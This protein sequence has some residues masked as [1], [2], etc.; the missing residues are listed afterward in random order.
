MRG[1]AGG[2]EALLAVIHPQ[3]ARVSACDPRAPAQDQLTERSLVQAGQTVDCHAAQVH[4]AA[5][6]ML[7]LLSMSCLC[8]RSCELGREGGQ[9]GGVSLGEHSCS[10]VDRLHNR[11]NS[12]AAV[13]SSAAQHVATRL[14][15]DGDFLDLLQL[16]MLDAAKVRH[17]L[18]CRCSTG[19]SL[20]DGE[21]DER[22][23]QLFLHPASMSQLQLQLPP[24]ALLLC[25]LLRCS[26]LRLQLRHLI[27]VPEALVE[28]D[29]LLLRVHEEEIH[30]LAV[31]RLPQ[32]RLCALEEAEGVSMMVGEGQQSLRQLLEIQQSD[33]P[34]DAPEGLDHDDAD[35]IFEEQLVVGG[36][37]L[38]LLGSHALDDSRHSAISHDGAAEHAH[39]VL[40][41][42]P[43]RRVRESRV[44]VEV[45]DADEGLLEG[46]VT[47]DGV[48]AAGDATLVAAGV[49]GEEACH[50]AIQQV[51]G[52]GRAGHELLHVL[53]Q[54]SEEL[55]EGRQ[56]GQAANGVQ[57]GA[58]GSD[59]LTCVFEL[60]LVLQ[61]LSKVGGDGLEPLLVLEGELPVALVHRQ[62][63]PH[64]IPSSVQQS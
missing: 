42:P 13:D 57:E 16:L 44:L 8:H 6:A 3:L 36:E 59:G 23:L 20:P 21:R 1:R 29:R 19:H 35:E 37:L 5:P 47:Y 18:T 48:G 25:C 27:R 62:H 45:G 12:L 55:V 9:E 46:H 40:P 43:P 10:L 17:S 53:P 63:H 54:L 32:R 39:G 30:P 38:L 2:Q 26:D 52:A 56:A 31:Q 58:I 24:L 15:Q 41:L 64:V 51:G 50:V 4:E 22:S 28:P 61:E 14:P 60:G 11:N 33:V 49:D 7:E 34:L